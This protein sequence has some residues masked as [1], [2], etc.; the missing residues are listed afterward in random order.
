MPDPIRSDDEIISYYRKI[1][2]YDL[3]HVWAT[4]LML[5]LPLQKAIPFMSVNHG[6]TEETWS[7]VQ[8]KGDK[9]SIVNE[10]EDFI[11]D[12]IER[13]LSHKKTAVVSLDYYRVW[14]WLMKD[15]DLFTYLIDDRNFPNFG[16]P[17][18]MAVI[19][20]YEMK[21]LLPDDEVKKFQFANMADGRKCQE[22]CIVC[23][24]GVPSPY[25]KNLILPNSLNP[26][27]VI[28]PKIIS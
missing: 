13:V 5:R 20:K 26:N 12:A 3:F 25:Q 6:W 17:M 9:E 24:Y 22:L 1:A 18:L 14:A 10:M 8:R 21:D 4:E 16:A 23:G 7:K 28:V 15:L 19:D 11:Q 27:N 2:P